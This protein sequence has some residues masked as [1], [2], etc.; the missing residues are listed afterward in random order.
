MKVLVTGGTGVVGT[1]TVTALV[2]A[3]HTVRLL[4]RHARRDARQWPAGV[5]SRPGNV[6]EPETIRGAA[7]GCD[8]VVHLVAIVD[9]SPPHATFERI[10]V[11]GTR[12]IVNEARR[13]GVR[14][15]VYI[16]SLG[17]DVGESPYHRSKLEGEEIVRTF[18]GNWTILRIGNVYGPG[19]EQISLLLRMVRTL[20]AVP[21]IGDGD[22]PIQPAW[23]EDIA[24]GIVRA[25]ERED[26][27]GRVL[28]LAGNDLTSQND[29]VERLSRITDRGVTRV[30]LP[31]LLASAGMK[32]LGLVGIEIPFNDSQR[33]MLAEGNRIAE[34]RPNGLTEVLGVTQTPLDEGL[35]R[36]ADAQEE[37]LPDEGVGSFKRKRFWGDVENSRLS[38]EALMEHLRTH[39]DDV[40]P[41]F[42]PTAAE[43]GTA[44]RVELGE[45]LTLS[46]PL[47][48]HV[49][50]R[51][52]ESTPRKVTLLTLEG[53][54]LAGAVRFLTEDRGECVRFEVQVFDRAANVIDLVAMRTVG[55]FLQ[56]RSWEAVVDNMVRASGGTLHGAIEKES[57]HLEGE[58]AERVE[59][60]LEELVVELR[61]GGK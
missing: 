49:Q 59:E 47:R 4:S 35:K 14:R 6:A 53:H 2:K 52:A 56:N 30:P 45:T 61:R 22:Q 24:T 60:W 28:E 10:N 42:L 26:L 51:V 37:Q 20:P 11:E 12:N 32:A 7:D 58:E 13:A 29:L 17:A 1:A 38:P 44:K 19:D 34:G 16:S 5:E 33:Q 43:P 23:H 39:F 55:D 9:E 25:T 18:G 27:A 54:P 21:L 57:A 50:V 36:L 46:I 40:T 8:A 31:D 48:G 15:F 41:N 3:G